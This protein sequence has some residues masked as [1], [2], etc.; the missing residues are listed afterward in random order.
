MVLPSLI[1]LH[2]TNKPTL[3]IDFGPASKGKAFQALVVRQTGEHQLHGGEVLR[4][5]GAALGRIDALRNSIGVTWVGPALEPF[6]RKIMS[7]VVTG[8]SAPHRLV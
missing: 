2:Q 5:H 3:C 8:F 4:D 7:T 1:V 6:A